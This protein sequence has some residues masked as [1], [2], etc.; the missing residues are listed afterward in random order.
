MESNQCT[1]FLLVAFRKSRGLHPSSVKLKKTH[2]KD[3]VVGV[4]NQHPFSKWD[5]SKITKVGPAKPTPTN[6]RPSRFDYH[7]EMQTHEANC[8]LTGWREFKHLGFV[9]E[10]T[11][12]KETQNLQARVAITDYFGRE[13]LAAVE[14][15]TLKNVSTYWR[16]EDML[17]D[18]P[19][20]FD[21]KQ[22]KITHDF[23]GMKVS[24]NGS[25]M[26]EYPSDPDLS[27]SDEAAEFGN[28]FG[29][30]LKENISQAFETSPIESDENT[31]AS[32]MLRSLIKL[33]I[34]LLRQLSLDP[35]STRFADSVPDIQRVLIQ[36]TKLLEPYVYFRIDPLLKTDQPVQSLEVVR[37]FK[38]R[39]EQIKKAASDPTLITP[40]LATLISSDWAG[41]LKSI[42]GPNWELLTAEMEQL[43][44][45]DPHG[46]SRF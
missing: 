43:S 9:G 31:C 37:E 20:T 36:Y 16:I 38:S 24:I 18:A 2:T 25:K 42:E 6:P 41:M 17:A 21:L 13:E 30:L 40:E 1:S 29:F 15:E 10:G 45:N 35:T 34:W 32:L 26:Y 39:Y 4:S 19:A 11:F 23:S 44:L 14:K 22:F 46:Y 33:R 7:M 5:P 28:S 12:D 3:V 27:P 8:S